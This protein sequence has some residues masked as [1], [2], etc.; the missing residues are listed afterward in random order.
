MIGKRDLSW[1]RV[2]EKISGC[3]KGSRERTCVRRFEVA[4][5]TDEIVVDGVKSQPR[6]PSGKVRE[7]AMKVERRSKRRDVPLWRGRYADTGGLQQRNPKDQRGEAQ[8][9]G[10]ASLR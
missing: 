2:V 6:G 4:D 9:T 5:A 1:Q 7:V 8:T 10:G 3:G